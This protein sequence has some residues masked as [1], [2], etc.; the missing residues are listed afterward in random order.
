MNKIIYL[1]I[2]ALLFIVLKNNIKKHQSL[3]NHIIFRRCNKYK[4]G[5]TLST[6]FDKYNIKK[7]IC[8][9]DTCNNDWN[10]Y[11]PCGYNSIE[12]E[13]R[14]INVNNNNQ[15][16]FG[17][18]G[19]D[20]IVSKNG[21]WDLLEKKYG[22]DNAVKIMPET[23]IINKKRDIKLFKDRFR[24]G[25][26]YILKKN[27]QQQKGLLISNN[28]YEILDNCVKDKKFRVIQRLLD[29]PFIVNGRKI[30][31]RVYGLIICN[32][33]NKYLYLH[34]RGFIYYTKKPFIKGSTISDVN[35]TTGYITRDIYKHNPLTHADL[36][37]HLKS[38]GINSDILF[39]NIDA[40]MVQ[41]MNA[42]GNALCNLNVLKNNITFQLFGID[43]APDESLNVQIMEMNKGPDMNAKDERDRNLKIKVQE[44][45]FD[46]LGIIRC[47]TENEFRLVW[48]KK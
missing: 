17:I 9:G 5:E 21:L 10:I 22:R 43:V 41:V 37:D 13:L 4:L 48:K 29:N 19:C 34:N 33:T 1:L 16:I 38:V 27:I 46:L 26:I 40:L 18:K 8:N 36:C 47:D 42:C 39:N 3:N 24:Q 31:M 28:M 30:N 2:A 32:G 14:R 44:D 6:I 25:D 23:Y 11:L 7:Q 35:I 20:N 12:S 45:V 15:K